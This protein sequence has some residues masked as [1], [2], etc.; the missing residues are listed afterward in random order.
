MCA[1]L[2]GAAEEELPE[3]RR[4][5]PNS[6]TVD[7]WP[8]MFNELHG[9]GYETLYSEDDALIGT[10][11]YRLYGFKEPPTKRYLRPFWKEADLT[12]NNAGYSCSQ[13][14]HIDYLKRFFNAFSNVNKFGVI[15]FS[16][17]S[18]NHMN[19][20]SVAD[21]DV[22]SFYNFLSDNKFNND[23][24]VIL[25]GDH[26]MRISGFRKTLQGKLEE[27]LPFMSITVPS[28]FHNRYPNE[29]QNIKENS[30]RLTSHFDIYSTI[31]HLVH[32]PNSES[33][34]CKYG[35]SLFTKFGHRT[36][37]Q[38][39][40]PSHWC[41]CLTYE[42]VNVTDKAALE[43][44]EKMIESINNLNAKYP[45]AKR[46]CSILSLNKILKASR[47]VPNKDVQH[48][49]STEKNKKCDS[50]KAKLD[51]SSKFK[52][53]I[54]EI[55]FSVHPSQG[56][57]EATADC[58]KKDDGSN[59]IR[60]KPGMSRVNEYGDQPKCIMRELPHLRRFC[61]CVK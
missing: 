5:F 18:H 25:F 46:K 7:K 3:A 41:P 9:L 53:Y 49:V 22:L 38:V 26:G 35:K 42:P 59:V 24:V 19:R 2:T 11:N 44:V 1:I 56:E 48:F 61:Y 20:I 13:Q 12:M 23:T 6:S 21:E 10:F 51:L 60:V 4:G 28:W 17:L 16:H 29:V 55:I 52:S 36:C 57:Y 27:R 37:A 32:F 34:S 15:L 50:C 45:D 47:R 8:F 31:K 58:M 14:Y 40:V 30:E 54:Y 43:V 39:G 33:T